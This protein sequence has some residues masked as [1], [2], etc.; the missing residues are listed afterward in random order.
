MK[1]PL[2]LLLILEVIIMA[3]AEAKILK[4]TIAGSWY[5]GTARSLKKMVY[6]FFSQAKIEKDFRPIALIVPHAGYI[7]SGKVAAYAYRLLIGKK[8]KR[9]FILGPAHRVFTNKVILSDSDYYQTPLGNIPIDKE[10]VSELLKSSSLFKVDENILLP[11]HSVQI[12]LPFLQLALNKFKIVP[13]VVGELKKEEILKVAQVLKKYLDSETLFIASSDFTHYGYS[14]GYLPFRENVEEKLRKLDHAAYQYIK[15]LDLEGF[16]SYLAETGITIC[17]FIPISI[18]LALLPSDSQAI[19]LKYDTSGNMLNDF[20]NS[21]SYFSIAFYKN[22]Q[23][24]NNSSSIL[25]AEEKKQLLKL[26]RAVLESYIREGK[27]P[28][29]EDIGIKLTDNLLQKRAAFVTLQKD[30]SLRGCIGDIFPSKPLYQVIIERTIDAAVNDPRFPPVSKQELESIK[31]EISALT[32]LREVPSY[33]DIVIGRD[34][35]YLVKG[36]QRA[37]FLPQVATEQGWDLETT[38]T[39]LSLKAGLQPYAWREGASFY[40]FQAEVFSEE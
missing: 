34:G 19:D 31:I 3:G 35:I 26:S 8:I 25:T 32:P 30:H 29:P 39:H 6:E 28:Q 37:V 18:L 20:S 40:V 38:L 15:K 2:F 13:L 1:K 22:S 9:V 14:Y 27:I 12:Q 21:V 4:S 33:Q 17:G 7:Y 36:F 11:E 16:L 10:V 5:P 24:R 23:G